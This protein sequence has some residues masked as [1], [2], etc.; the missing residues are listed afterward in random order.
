M[1]TNFCALNRMWTH[2]LSVQI[3]KAY[4]PQTV[5]SLPLAV[6]FNNKELQNFI[7]SLGQLDYYM[8]MD[9]HKGYNT[10]R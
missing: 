3:I 10:S 9:E 5:W 1:M 6:N 2:N 7:K 8:H 4:T